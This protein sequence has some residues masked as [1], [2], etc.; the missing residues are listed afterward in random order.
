MI[1]S[2]T[3]LKKN[4]TVIV[5]SGR[6]KGKKG[7][8]LEVDRQKNKILIEGIN[9]IKRHTKPNAQNQQGGIVEKEAFISISNVL[10]FSP[11]AERGVRAKI[12]ILEDGSRIRVCRV[13]GDEI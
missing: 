7:K 8:V 5:I 12:K 6:N 9:M 10:L 4:D 3:K 1:S 2:K 11:S 13:T